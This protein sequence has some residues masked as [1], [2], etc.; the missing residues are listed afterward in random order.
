MMN[1]QTMKTATEYI[2]ESWKIYTKKENFV[3]FARIMAVLTIVTLL[4][5]YVTGY[6][7][8]EDYLKSGDFTNIPR[9]ISYISISILAIILSL[10]SQTTQYFAIFKMRESEKEVLR[11]GF[12]KMLRFLIINFTLGVIV[13]FGAILLIIPAI[14]FGVRYSF[15]I[16]LVLDKD[17]S[18]GQALKASYDMVWG[19]FWKVLGRS[20]VFGLATFIVSVLLS[21]IPYFG[22]VAVTFIAP[23]FLLPYYLMYKDLLPND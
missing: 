20:V 12:K 5:S 15:A 17:M 18:I 13:V 10:W 21:V 1:T 9:L 2:K 19:K 23:L 6:F 11:L 8:P 4:I 14:I 16:L 22:S 3:F 7:F